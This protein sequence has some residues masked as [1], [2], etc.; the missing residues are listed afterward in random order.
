MLY[1][2]NTLKNRKTFLF[3][4]HTSRRCHF[5]YVVYEP[6]NIIHPQKLGNHYYYYCDHAKHWHVGTLLLSF[7]CSD[8]N[9]YDNV[10]THVLLL[11]RK[12]ITTHH[13]SRRAYMAKME[14]RKSIV[15]LCVSAKRKEG[16]TRCQEQKNMFNLV[17]RKVPV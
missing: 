9:K 13:I 5:T 2:W 15:E 17:L 1:F 10:D 7:Y 12:S 11:W 16:M 8:T 6:K 14:K 3:T 4:T